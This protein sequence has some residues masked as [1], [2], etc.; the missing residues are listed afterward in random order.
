[1]NLS[2]HFVAAFAIGIAFFHNAELALIVSIGA[3][4]PDLDREYFYA[5]RDFMGKYQTHR[6]LLHNFVVATLLYIVQSF[7][8]TRGSKPLFSRHI[9][10]G[11]GPRS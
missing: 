5:A 11:Y 10:F 4:L 7:S 6:A 9:H 3:L 2:T 8:G 1:M